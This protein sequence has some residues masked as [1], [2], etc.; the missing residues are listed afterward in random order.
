M[1]DFCDFEDCD[2][3]SFGVVDFSSLEVLVLVE[4]E[5]ELPS[6]LEVFVLVS[7][8]SKNKHSDLEV[9]LV[10]PLLLSFTGML[11]SLL[12]LRPLGVVPLVPKDFRKVVGDG[13]KDVFDLDFLVLFFVMGGVELL[14]TEFFV[15]ELMLSTEFLVVVETLNSLLEVFVLVSSSSTFDKLSE[16]ALALALKLTFPLS[17][18]LLF[19]L[20]LIVVG[21]LRFRLTPRCPFDVR[22]VRTLKLL[23]RVVPRTASVP[24]VPKNGCGSNCFWLTDA[25]AFDDDA[26]GFGFQLV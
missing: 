15:A 13:D 18:A 5:T 24:E 11:R 26:V 17:P 21:M 16:L 25:D 3:A 1:S 19:R 23:W 14:P 10:L 9:A 8:S 20:G 12:I 6:V 22:R 2:L 7:S 4:G